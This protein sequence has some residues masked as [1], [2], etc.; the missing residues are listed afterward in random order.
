MCEDTGCMNYYE[1]NEYIIELQCVD[2]YGS[3]D[4]KNLTIVVTENESPV[5][6]NLP[7]K[8]SIKKTKINW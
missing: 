4:N 2:A 1:T 3:S 7:G 5:L 8:S 6:T